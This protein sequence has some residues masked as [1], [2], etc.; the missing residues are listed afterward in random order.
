[1]NWSTDR[2]PLRFSRPLGFRLDQI[3]MALYGGLR[4]DHR[5]MFDPEEKSGR[6]MKH[7][8]AGQLEIAMNTTTCAQPARIPRLLIQ[9]GV[10]LLIAFFFNTLNYR[11]VLAASASA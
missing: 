10:L 3:P 2:R 4:Y 7:Q 1:M 9:V 8:N 6:S 11:E 5:S